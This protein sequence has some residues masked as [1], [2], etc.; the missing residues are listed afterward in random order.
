M[1]Q[2]AT[3]TAAARPRRARPVRKRALWRD[4]A[5]R[6]SW[7]KLITLLLVIAPGLSTAVLLALNDLGARPL[8]EAIHRTGEWAIRLVLIALAVTPARV[9]LDWARAVYLRRMLGVSAAC[10]AGAHFLLYCADKNWA[11]GT[12]ASEIVLRVYLT[13][14]FIA[15]V[16]MQALAI[17]STNAA[18]RRMGRS[19]T[20]LHR[21]IYVLAVLGIL[22]YFMQSKADVSA[23]V[24][25][26]GLYVWLMVWRLVP[27][28]LAGRLWV[29]PLLAIAA[30]CATVGI[31]AL[32][33]AVATRVDV[34]RVVEANLDIAYGPR[35]AVQVLMVGVLICLVASGRRGLLRLRRHR[36]APVARAA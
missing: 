28:R 32:W 24:F 11:P 31:E 5:G 22:H 34:A 3:A 14:G 36:P 27:R 35:P 18:I 13:I 12:V 7:L 1:S 20:T 10:Y 23:A 33:Y 29:L 21:L 26:A 9:V 4:P 25:V 17:T 30:A 15:L 2:S 19:W 8:T 16:L 6:F